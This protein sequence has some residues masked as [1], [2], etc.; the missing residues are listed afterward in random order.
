[1]STNSKVKLL[2]NS[3]LNKLIYMKQNKRNISRL[4]KVNFKMNFKIQIKSGIKN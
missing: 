3:N 1:M 4:T 2:L